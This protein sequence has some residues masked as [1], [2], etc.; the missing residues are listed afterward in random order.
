MGLDWTDQS[1]MT[2]TIQLIEHA[3]HSITCQLPAALLV[4]PKMNNDAMGKKQLTKT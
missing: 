3:G 2:K 1:S 4:R